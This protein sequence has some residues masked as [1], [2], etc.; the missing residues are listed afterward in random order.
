MLNTTLP[1]NKPK[2]A[3][4]ISENVLYSFGQGAVFLL[5]IVLFSVP[6]AL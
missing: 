2:M 5:L 1:S 6:R 3:A 4:Y